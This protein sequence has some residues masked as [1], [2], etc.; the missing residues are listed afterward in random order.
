MLPECRNRAGGERAYSLAP[1]Q[2]LSWCPRLQAAV[3]P[4]LRDAGLGPCKPVPA[5]PAG[6]R[7]AS[8]AGRHQASS[9]LCSLWACMVFPPECPPGLTPFCT[10][11][12]I[13]WAFFQ[14]SQ[15]RLHQAFPGT[16]AP[17]LPGP[18]LKAQ[19]HW[20]H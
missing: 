18:L 16:L 8:T 5:G 14:N 19:G 11:G 4:L 20:E 9:F 10:N 12:W 7:V 6:L 1:G 17:A 13:Q 2:G 3:R 15:E